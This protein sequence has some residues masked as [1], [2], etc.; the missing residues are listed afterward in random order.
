MSTVSQWL[1]D[2]SNCKGL[3]RIVFCCF[4]KEDENIYR[5]VYSACLLFFD[6]FPLSVNLQRPYRVMIRTHS[7]FNSRPCVHDI[8]KFL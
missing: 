6:Y 7:S 5:Q 1:D 4:L 3:D 8:Y 2:E